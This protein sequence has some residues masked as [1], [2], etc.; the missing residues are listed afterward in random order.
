M[1]N[2]KSLLKKIE[3]FEKLAVLGDRVGFMKALAQSENEV[4]HTY[5]PAASGFLQFLKEQNIHP[6]ELTDYDYDQMYKEYEGKISAPEKYKNQNNVSQFN[7]KAEASKLLSL[8]NKL[9]SSD[10]FFSDTK[11]QEQA[12]N[13]FAKLENIAKNYPKALSP[14]QKTF[15]ENKKQEA[16]ASANQ[17]IKYWFDVVSKWVQHPAMFDPNETA[18]RSAVNQGLNELTRLSK[19]LP[20]SEQK[21]KAE[22]LARLISLYNRKDVFEPAVQGMISSIWTKLL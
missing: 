12:A 2:R 13:A 5:D 1:E 15:L 21:S 7:P 10:G 20:P 16:G 6:N 8:L 3:A 4:S 18:I 9:Y 22:N 11:L 17:K 14:D 19:T